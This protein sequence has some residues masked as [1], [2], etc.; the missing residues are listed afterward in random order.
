MRARRQ[1]AR[2]QIPQHDER[3]RGERQQRPAVEPFQAGPDDDQHGH[4]ADG[5]RR[6]AA[7][8]DPL[9]EEQRRR[10]GPR[11]RHRLDDRRGVG[12]RH[13]G[14]RREVERRRADLADGA[15]RQKRSASSPK[16]A[17]APCRQATKAT[18][19][20]VM[21]LRRMMICATESSSLA[22]FTNV[23]LRMKLIV[24]AIMNRMPRE[25]SLNLGEGGIATGRIRAVYQLT[26]ISRKA[27]ATQASWDLSQRR[28]LHSHRLRNGL[29]ISRRASPFFPRILPANFVLA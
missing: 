22:S 10:G 5:D 3:D 18:G 15:E 28:K 11:Q 8:A 23:S 19:G 4:E 12:D 14:E 17:N 24:D 16:L 29:V 25:F 1:E 20:A 2:G 6:P 7:D 13:M 9:V 26:R 21:R 27:A